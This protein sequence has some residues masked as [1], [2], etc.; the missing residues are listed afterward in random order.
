MEGKSEVGA[1]DEGDGNIGSV[2]PELGPYILG[3]GPVGNFLRVRDMGDDLTYWEGIGQIL[4]QVGLN[5]YGEAT[6]AIEG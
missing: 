4:P 2:C 3:G 5:D 1:T 6:S